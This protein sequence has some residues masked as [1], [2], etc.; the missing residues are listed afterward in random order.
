[1]GEADG[2]R[3]LTA[4]L[5]LCPSARWVPRQWVMSLAVHDRVSM[6]KP[7]ICAYY[8]CICPGPVNPLV[9]ETR[10]AFRACV[11][12]SCSRHSVI[13]ATNTLVKRIGSLLAARQPVPLGPAPCSCQLCRSG[14]GSASPV[15]VRGCVGVMNQHAALPC[16]LGTSATRL[17]ARWVRMLA[18]AA[19]RH[20]MR[21]AASNRCASSSVVALLALICFYPLPPHTLFPNPP[22]FMLAETAGMTQAPAS[23]AAHR[24]PSCQ[25][26]RSPPP[27]RCAVCCGGRHSRWLAPLFCAC[28][29]AT[30]ALRSSMDC[31][32]SRAAN[33]AARS[34][35]PWQRGIQLVASAMDA[36]WS[37]YMKFIYA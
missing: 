36:A 3:N 1:M 5:R 17:L 29:P 26:W 18:C 37:G 16:G 33:M 30:A 20:R 10:F 23:A 32:T 25:S 7:Q 6:F 28:L 11:L 14:D 19:M 34:G 9:E 13:S 35:Q 24:L 2:E 8:S 12:H 21:R 4:S 27:R 15:L 22:C 31:N